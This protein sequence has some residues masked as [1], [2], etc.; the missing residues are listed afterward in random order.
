MKL[1]V[2]LIAVL[3]LLF[4]GVWGVAQD[5]SLATPVVSDDQVLNSGSAVFA[6]DFSDISATV[7][8][9]DFSSASPDFAMDGFISN[10]PNDD[11]SIS[12]M[13]TAFDSVLS[14]GLANARGG[15]GQI[16]L[17][18]LMAGQTYE[19]QLFAGGFTEDADSE[20]ISDGSTP[21]DLAL[22]GDGSGVGMIIETFV[23]GDDGV[24]NIDVNPDAEL[25]EL[26]AINLREETAV[27]PDPADAPEPATWLLLVAGAFLMWRTAGWF[28]PSR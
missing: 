4:S 5:F 1:Q 24:E 9:V 7:N 19:L 14:V 13:S 8:G 2:P 17:S 22:G 10:M 23:A 15:M 27:A 6:V 12:T 21:G 3:A 26:N 25:I 20:T 11:S 28:Q 18:G 16:T